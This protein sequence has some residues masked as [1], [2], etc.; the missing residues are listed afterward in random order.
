MLRALLLSVTL[1]AAA[2]AALAWATLQSDMPFVRVEWPGRTCPTVQAYHPAWHLGDLLINASP[3]EL[4]ALIGDVATA[5]ESVIPTH[6]ECW[7]YEFLGGTSLTLLVRRGVVE[8]TWF[9]HMS[10]VPDLCSG[11]VKR[12]ARIPRPARP[13][14]FGALETSCILW[15]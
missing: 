1:H 15:M 8:A 5:S 10:A 9:G 11:I 4:H 6:T 3:A 13:G 7:H 14:V 2:L 12:S